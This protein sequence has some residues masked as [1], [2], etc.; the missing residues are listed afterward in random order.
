[1]QLKSM[2]KSNLY[3]HPNKSGLLITTPLQNNFSSLLSLSTLELSSLSEIFS[4]YIKN[5]QLCLAGIPQW[6]SINP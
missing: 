1:M 6:L 3:V 2:N 5:F 4:L